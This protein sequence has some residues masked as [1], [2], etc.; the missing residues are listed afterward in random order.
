MKIW[1][2]IIVDDEPL[3][4]LELKRLLGS[5]NQ[6]L[7]IDEASSVPSAKKSIELHQP[8]LLFLDIN[9]GTQSGFDLL[10][11]IEHNFQTI[12]VTAYDKYAIRAFENNALDYLLKPVHPERLKESISRLGNPFKNEIKFNL[13]PYDKLLVSN[14][15]Y[16][17]FIS[18]SSI[19]YIEAKGDYTCI[20][21]IDEYK[22][23][24]HQTIKKWT[25]RLPENMF[26]QVHRSFIVNINLVQQI[27]KNKTGNFEIILNHSNTI[28]PISRN[29]LKKIKSKFRIDSK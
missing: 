19:M 10:E 8:D 24:V 3:A 20:N 27:K 18:V 26:I 5:Y 25:E 12:F 29:H 28:I 6:I 14:H 13:E 11:I 22:G 17:K 15:A 1:R 9:L 2:A 16:S 7:I 21:V 23:I 4:R